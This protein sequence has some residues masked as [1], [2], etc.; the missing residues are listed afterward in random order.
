MPSVRMTRFARLSGFLSAV[1]LLAAQPALSA[2]ITVDSLSG[3][4]GGPSCSLRD[5]ITAANTDAP[6]AGCAAGSGADVIVLSVSGVIP[7]TEADNTTQGANG[8]PVILG[9]I[10]IDGN[11]ATILRDPGLTCTLD[12]VTDVGEFRIAH[13]ANGGSLTL[14]DITLVNGCADGAGFGG[15]GGALLVW[16]NANLVADGV[17][18]SDSQAYGAGG[19]LVIETAST[20]VLTNT[21]VT[22]NSTIGIN[23]GGGIRF[24]GASMLV[25][26]SVISGNLSTDSGGGLML[27]S[28]DGLTTLLRSTVDGNLSNSHGGGVYNFGG[29]RVIES[30]ISNNTA[31]GSGGGILSTN[32]ADELL[33]FNS[34][35]SGNSASNGG[36]IWNSTAMRIGYST[37]SGNSAS[38][39]GGGLVININIGGATREVLNSIIAGNLSGGDC[40]FDVAPTALGVNLAGDGSCTGFS[41]P[42]TNPMLAPLANYGGSTMTHALYVGSPAIDAVPAGACEDFSAAA[43]TGDQ[44]GVSR[45]LDGNNDSQSTCDIGAVEQ[46]FALPGPVQPPVSAPVPVPMLG[47]WGLALLGLALA[48]VSARRLRG[49]G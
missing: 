38:G 29:L 6:V 30:T 41:L 46:D 9:D 20:A 3:G 12:G 44:R 40:A 31:T 5:A 32:I 4:T 19:G 13:V 18:I 27:A 21:A 35:V 37:I 36:G 45:P 10:T 34:T 39:S 15:W 24:G 2:T 33:V 28:S 11:G 23:G 26:D 7:L 8:L 22:N 42:N 25:E 16:A 43:L 17:T 47:G 49:R 48:G 14:N 1:S